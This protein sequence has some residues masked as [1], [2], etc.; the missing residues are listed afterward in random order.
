MKYNKTEE[1]ILA[2]KRAHVIR[3]AEWVLSKAYRAAPRHEILE[4]Q[5]RMREIVLREAK[6][7]NPGV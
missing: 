1:L 5:V 2:R 4:S 6:R 3:T 7:R